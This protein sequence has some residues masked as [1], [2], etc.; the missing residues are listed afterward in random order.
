[1]TRKHAITDAEP[2]VVVSHGADFFGQDR[3]ILKDVAALAPWVT[4]SVPYDDRKA[5]APLV[6]AL[7][8]PEPRAFPAAEAARVSEQ[9]LKVSRTRHMKPRA[10]ALARTL[11]DA[12]ARAA[13][14][15]EPW[16]WTVETANEDLAAAL[17]DGR[18][19]IATTAGPAI[20]TGEDW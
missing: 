2:S 10:S 11:A 9:L 13:A 20:G 15:G 8:H 3:H 17:W 1:M 4:N 19:L 12:A 6:A 14:D 7:E 18:G 5:V 16:T